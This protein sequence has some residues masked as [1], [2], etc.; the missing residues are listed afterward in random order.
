MIRFKLPFVV[1]PGER[2]LIIPGQKRQRKVLSTD[3]MAD[4][5]R[6][7]IGAISRQ[8]KIRV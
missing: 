6:T 2:K 4:F 5:R 8:G 1:L 3:V 7:S